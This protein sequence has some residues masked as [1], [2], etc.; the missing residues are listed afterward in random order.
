VRSHGT[1]GL[2]V[3]TA[4]K[5]L[6]FAFPAARKPGVAILGNPRNPCVTPL[7]ASDKTPVLYAPP[8]K[9][10]GFRFRDAHNARDV[11]E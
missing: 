9:P 7:A 8:N 5:P 11:R 2:A 1:P 3:R 4:V 6:R 10:G